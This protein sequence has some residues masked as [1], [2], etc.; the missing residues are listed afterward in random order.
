MK[1]IYLDANGSAPALPAAREKITSALL[2][3]GNPSSSHGHGRALRCL[4]DEAR[5]HVAAAVVAV[6]KEVIFT[7]GASESNRLFVDALTKFAEKLE[8]PLS[9]LMSPYEH[10]SLYKP[11]LHDEKHFTITIMQIDEQGA[12]VVTKEMLG[13]IDVMIACHAHNETG[14]VNDLMQLTQEL[15]PDVVVMSDISQALARENALSARIDVMT[16]SAQKMGGFSGA[17]ALVV[18]GNGKKLPPPWLGGG[19]ERGFRPGTES[20]L[21]LAAF[22]E[23]AKHIEDSR[24][25]ARAQCALRD[26]FEDQIMALAPVTILGKNVRRLPNTSAI[27]FYEE[28]AD[29]LRIAC[30]LAGLSVGFGAACSGL[31]PEG[32]FALKRLGLSRED[33]RKTVRFSLPLEATRDAIDETVRRLGDFVLTKKK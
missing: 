5:V 31:A 22:G 6:P 4:I 21:M 29:A 15:S 12:L 10:P 9:I 32:S 24:R 14:I 2:L 11:L 3:V 17:G 18:R 30:D 1:R 27:C 19:Q 25:R 7:S 13:G 33:E 26:V 28:D 20:V 23:A 16:C 8:R